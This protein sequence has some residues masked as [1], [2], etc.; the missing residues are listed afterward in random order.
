MCSVLAKILALKIFDESDPEV[1]EMIHISAVTAS[2]IAVSNGTI[3]ILDD[4]SGKDSRNFTLHRDISASDCP[5][6]TVCS[7]L[8]FFGYTAITMKKVC[9]L[10]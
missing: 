2:G 1:T 5:W 10:C 9:G 7:T 6:L 3:D 4:N 8:A